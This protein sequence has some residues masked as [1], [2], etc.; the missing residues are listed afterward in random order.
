MKKKLLLTFLSL[1]ILSASFAQ[2]NIISKDSMAY[3]MQMQD[4]IFYKRHQQAREAFLIDLDK[5]DSDSAF[6]LKYK[7]ISISR[8]PRY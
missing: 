1:I 4:D 6:V 7:S 2:N 5:I 8:I 3:Y